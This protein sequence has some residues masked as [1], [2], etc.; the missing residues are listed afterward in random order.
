MRRLI[1]AIAGA[2]MLA[3]TPAAAEQA[4][5]YDAASFRD[6][7]HVFKA[8]DLNNNGALSHYEYAMM[9][10]NMID[11]RRL[12][13]YRGD[14]ARTMD[15][16]VDR[17]FAQL[18]RNDDGS[19]SRTEFMNIASDPTAATAAAASSVWDWSPEYVTLTYYLLA[20]PIDT[21]TFE[22]QPVRNLAGEEVGRIRAIA[23]PEGSD[24]V[25]A[26]VAVTDVT[27]DPTPTRYRGRMIGIPLDDI[28][29]AKDGTSL[30]LSGRGEEYL[31]SDQGRP[32]VDI[33]NME[34]V[35]TLYGV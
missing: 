14:A 9:R 15:A 3:A 6:L 17:G 1:Y 20:N 30:Y 5:R 8:A 2:T 12:A 13:T 29:L 34:K 24:N 10:T 7:A 21:D 16:V 27:M 35:E 11:E 25:Y 28:L 4:G 31:L 19:I 33:D 32:R 26:L 23:S 18:D 22:Q